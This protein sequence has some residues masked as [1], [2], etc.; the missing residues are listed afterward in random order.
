MGCPFMRLGRLTGP[1]FDG[2]VSQVLSWARKGVV[3]YSSGRDSGRV[4]GN[5]SFMQ[6]T[7]FHQ[8]R[9]LQAQQVHSV[10]KACPVCLSESPREE[11]FRIQRD[12]DIHFL[13]CRACH[14]CSASHMPKPEVLDDYY[15]HYYHQPDKKITFAGVGK[16][17]NHLLKF[18]GSDGLPS[19]VRML[20]FGGGDGTLAHAI[21][22]KLVD[23]D[24]GRR[25]EI[26]LV[27][28]QPPALVGAPRISFTHHERLDSVE[29]CYDLILAS[30]I[31]EHIPQVNA[32][33]HKLFSLAAPGAYF[34]ARTPY[35]IPLCSIFRR[36]D[37]TYPA[38]VHDMGAGFWN[39][40]PKTFDLA[41]TVIASGP[42]I[43][44]TDLAHQ[45]LR[46]TAAYFM[47]LPARL[48]RSRPGKPLRD[49]WWNLV[50]GWEMI[51]R[52]EP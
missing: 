45:P 15:A 42:S 48:S 18:I 7:V 46:T 5:G 27:D 43:I 9:H 17:A 20:D 19:R 4:Q 51:L 29:G 13:R 14:A 40:L 41:T 1:V 23:T 12:P 6:A 38:H 50:G 31:L 39:R 34:Y 37:V 8:S 3:D 49:P 30:A 21:A 25:V 32:V 26:T 33:F 24:P 2:R 35:V 36:M 16:F 44:E 52:F 11:V 28:Y 10:A 47:K 22:S